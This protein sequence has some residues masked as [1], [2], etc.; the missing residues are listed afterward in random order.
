MSESHFKSRG[1]EQPPPQLDM[2]SAPA[3]ERAL[4]SLNLCSIEFPGY[5]SPAS[6]SIKSA[7]SHLGGQKNLDRAFKRNT[8]KTDSLLELSWRPD[9][10]FAHK[11]TGDVVHT[12]N[13]LLKVTKRRRKRRCDEGDAGPSS[14]PGA[15]EFTIEALGI[16]NKVGRFRGVK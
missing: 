3:A 10:P 4:P 16:I 11:V 6:T 9:D 15:G 2:P 13:I 5:V 8:S 1:L 14:E 7:I 12:T